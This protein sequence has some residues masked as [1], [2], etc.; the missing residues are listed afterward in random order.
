M[1]MCELLKRKAIDFL[2]KGSEIV[3]IEMGERKKYSRNE[4]GV[5]V[6][7]YNF[8]GETFRTKISGQLSGLEKKYKE[9]KNENE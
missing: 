8:K 6:I 7:I 1:I 9:F 5:V 4:C 2:P 3:S